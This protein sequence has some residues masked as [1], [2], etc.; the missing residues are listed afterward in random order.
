MI[1]R[2]RIVEC[3]ATASL[4]RVTLLLA[5]A[6]SGKSVALQQY[7]AILEDSAKRFD[8]GR[9]FLTWSAEC[10]ASFSGTIALDGLERYDAESLREIVASIENANRAIRW[11]IASRSAIG[12]PVGTWLAY[13]ECDLPIAAPELAFTHDELSEAARESALTT[14]SGELRELLA[15]IDGWPAAV[16]VALQ[17]LAK[18]NDRREAYA[19]IRDASDRFWLEQVYGQLDDEERQF[20]AVAAALPLIDVKVLERA[21]FGNALQLAD[22]LRLRTGLLHDEGDGI[23]RCPELFLEFLRRRTAFEN[24]R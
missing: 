1:V 8:D 12:I 9:A 21:G 4:R 19:A 3:I 20:F 18:S 23:Y 11:I 14:D 16:P 2:P 15:A 7:L 13:R 17:V 22:D 5:P 6:G 24:A 10:L